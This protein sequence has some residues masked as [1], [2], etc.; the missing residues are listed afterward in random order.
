VPPWLVSRAEGAEARRLT[1]T[2]LAIRALGALVLTAC[3]GPVAEALA[4]FGAD[5][6]GLA[7][8]AH[9]AF[10]L[11]LM[12]VFL[13]LLDP[14]M[15][16][17]T[18]LLPAAPR[19]ADG[20]Q[21][22]EPSVLPHPALALA[23]AARE[24]LRVGDLVRKMLE[25]AFEAL[26]HPSPG[27]R[28]TT[29]DLDDSVD[30]LQQAIKLYI[31]RLDR[32]TLSPADARRSDEII[33]YAINLEHIGDIIDRGLASMAAKKQKRQVTFSVE[34]LTELTE[35]YDKTVENMQ[36][37]QSVFFTRDA[38]LARQLVEAKVE[39]RRLESLSAER[40]LQRVRAQRAE[41]LGS[42]TLH[43]DILRDLKRVNSHLTAVAYPILQELGELHES[44]LR[45]TSPGVEPPVM[46]GLPARRAG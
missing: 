24:T 15:L 33:S 19:A 31:A 28:T 35:L 34:G 45:S 21:Y 17:A 41:T 3:A 26:V 11:T 39:V 22:L 7:I 25:C 9:I 43:L 27:A 40:H 29:S 30:R 38:N 2:N 20:P 46:A 12:A 5:P 36:L 6:K 16:A 4:M 23:G 42:S 18:K 13:V 44:R 14:L 10:N 1:L 37:S 8:G 32:E